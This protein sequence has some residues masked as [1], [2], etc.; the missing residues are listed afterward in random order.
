MSIG[1]KATLR[2]KFAS[3]KQ[4]EALFC[5]LKPET[6]TIDTRRAN[7]HL[8]K[9]ACFLAL[10]VEADDTVALR[11]TLNAYLHWIQSTLNV[12]EV[13]EQQKVS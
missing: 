9:D 2:L 8:R 11:A 5:A 7:V 4:L 13:L 1:A 10:T 3:E 6:H 12:I